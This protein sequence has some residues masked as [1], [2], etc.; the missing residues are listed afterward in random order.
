MIDFADNELSGQQWHRVRGIQFL[1]EA[2][3]GEFHTQPR[4]QAAPVTVEAAAE[5]AQDSIADRLPTIPEEENED[6]SN[7]T[8]SPNHDDERDLA[9]WSLSPKVVHHFTDSFAELMGHYPNEHAMDVEEAVQ[10]QALADETLRPELLFYHEAQKLLPYVHAPTNCQFL[11]VD[12]SKGLG[13][14]NTSSFQTS[15]DGI[16]TADARANVQRED[17]ALTAKDMEDNWADVQREMREELTRWTKYK[18]I[19]RRPRNRCKN[20]I[21]IRWVIRWKF[22]VCPVTNVRKRGI[23]ARLTARGF[24][25]ASG[26]DQSTY[27]ATATRLSQRLV[28]SE[29]ACRNWELAQV[30]ITK[31]FL[32]GVSYEELAAESGRPINEVNFEVPAG[33]LPALR[34]IEG[35]ESFDPRYE[36]LGLLK[37]GTGLRD[38]PKAF[39]IKLRK[40]THEFG[41]RSSIVDSEL[42]YLWSGTTHT[43]EKPTDADNVN[44]ADLIGIM[45]K[46]V[47]DLKIA[48]KPEIRRRFVAHLASYFG[49]PDEEARQFTNC[50]VTHSQSSDGTVLMNQHKFISAI[51]P[52]IIPDLSKEPDAVLTEPQ[53]R[54]FLSSLM[55]VAYA[56][57]TRPDIQVFVTALQR[58]CS[59]PQSQHVR[60]LNKVIKYVQKHPKQ[61]VYRSLG[62]GA[63]QLVVFSDASF[64][65]EAGQGR[66]QRGAVILRTRD[67]IPQPLTKVPH[68]QTCHLI[69]WCS[70]AQRRV[71]RSTFSSELLAAVDAVDTA[72]LVREILRE[73][74]T[75]EQG[76][77]LAR[78]H[79]EDPGYDAESK[80]QLFIDA[81]SVLDALGGAMARLPAEKSQV[82]HIHWLRELLENKVLCGVSW[83]DTRDMVADAM[84][85]GTISRNAVE[86]SL[87]GEF[88]FQHETIACEL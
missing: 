55:T 54:V 76:S 1:F 39:S 73:I 19:E 78:K 74:S 45:T 9:A 14:E 58:Q 36:V 15:K 75:G 33:T 29:A 43:K 83:C 82:I 47:D 85:K 6:Q 3:D 41:W 80:L 17:D 5:R 81:K 40:V 8:S 70:T 46:H 18:C 62:A 68:K 67:M 79:V 32:Q 86:S 48:T 84:T 20:I 37:P 60:R 44:P 61:L 24:K 35:Y 77:R 11:S 69:D 16:S 52:C 50:G 28:A 49:K 23:R 31:A 27:S 66:S 88:E 7:S 25:D 38:A 51:R 53:R 10:L 4:S 42:E 34:S 64:C 72:L 12:I 59:Q 13:A 22:I 26:D 21:D 56:S 87:N 63:S 71:T 65:A 2:D 57:L 30:D